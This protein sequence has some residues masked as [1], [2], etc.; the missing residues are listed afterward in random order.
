MINQICMCNN[1]QTFLSGSWI[2]TTL[3]IMLN[4]DDYQMAM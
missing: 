4:P 3:F 2:G 1:D